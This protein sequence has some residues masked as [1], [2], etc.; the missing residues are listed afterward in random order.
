MWHQLIVTAMRTNVAVIYAIPFV[1]YLEQELYQNVRNMYLQ[2][3]SQYIINA[4]KRFIGDCFLIWNNNYN[5]KT[6]LD[7]ANSLD[8]F[9]SFTVETGK[10]QLPFLDIMVIKN[11]DNSISTDIFYKSTNSHRYLDFH[12][13]HQHHTKS[14]YPLTLPKESVKLY[15]ITKEKF[16][17]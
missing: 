6:F 8:I 12:S 14:T 16:T 7:M 9:I 4:L 3:Y 15:P 11:C 5:L 17:D 2:D 13:C 1:A 10:H